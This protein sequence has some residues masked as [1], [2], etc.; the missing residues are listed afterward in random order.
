MSIT[1]NA[2]QTKTYYQQYDFLKMIETIRD[3]ST[4]NL[5]SHFSSQ[6]L[7]RN[8]AKARI[9]RMVAE[10]K[11]RSDLAAPGWLAD[12]WNKGTVQKE[13]MAA[14]LQEVNWSKDCSSLLLIFV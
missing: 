6:E 14:V 5:S 8:A 13:Q 11:K 10:K 1:K 12:E 2:S 3:W 7:L 9:R 4:L